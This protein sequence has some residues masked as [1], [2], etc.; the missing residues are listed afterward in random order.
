MLPFVL[1]S[2]S[3]ESYRYYLTSKASTECTVGGLMDAFRHL[4]V[5][6]YRQAWMRLLLSV[7]A[8]LHAPMLFVTLYLPPACAHTISPF[9]THKNL[10][11]Q[12]RGMWIPYLLCPQI[13]LTSLPPRSNL[14][15][16]LVCCLLPR[17]MDHHS[18][19]LKYNLQASPGPTDL[20]P[21]HRQIKVQLSYNSCSP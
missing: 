16:L 15:S 3:T 5:L 9:I 21:G 1:H 17:S 4:G 10:T 20:Y 2:T 18:G 11:R 19:Q 8:F 13:L 12:S 6:S 14:P 7:I